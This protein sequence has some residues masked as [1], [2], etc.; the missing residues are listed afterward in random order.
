MK[1]LAM[2]LLLFALKEVSVAQTKPSIGQIRGPVAAQ[3]QLLVLVNG[4]LVPVS[5]G[6]G[7]SLVLN[8]GAY[9]LRVVPVPASEVR[10]TRAANGAWTLPASCVLQSV[11]RNG[12]RQHAASDFTV[13]GTELRFRE[14]TEASDPSDASDTVIAECR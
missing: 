4:R 9:E 12:L 11:Y 6:A 7:V 10:L 1:K 14:G 2:A 8:N 13:S 3:G 5:L